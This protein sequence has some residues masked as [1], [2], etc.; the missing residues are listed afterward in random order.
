MALSDPFQ[1]YVEILLLLLDLRKNLGEK[2][3]RLICDQTRFAFNR[4]DVPILIQD[5]RIECEQKGGRDLIDSLDWI[6]Q[7]AI[8]EADLC[9]RR[10][11]PDRETLHIGLP[12]RDFFLLDSNRGI[13][14]KELIANRLRFI[15]EGYFR[16]LFIRV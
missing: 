9:L 2:P 6:S 11:L 5:D 16:I 1:Q 13:R 4:L 15:P 7:Q 12:E 8:D 3:E 14:I 10:V